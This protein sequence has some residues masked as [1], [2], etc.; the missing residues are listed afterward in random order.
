V[1]SVATVLAGLAA[2]A[3]V[4]SE[5]APS[6]DTRRADMPRL[7]ANVSRITGGVR[8]RITGSSWH[9][10]CP[11]PR[12]DLR[13][14]RLNHWDFG[15]DLERGRLIVNEDEKHEVVL[16]MRALFHARFPIRK[17]NLVDRY[18]ADDRRS[19]AADNTSAFNC[20][21]VAGTSRWSE[22]AFGRAIDINPVENPYV[23]GSHVSPPAGRPYVDRSRNAKGMIH[24]GDEVWDA[25][26][27]VGWRWGG[28]W[29]GTK[30][31]QHFSSTGN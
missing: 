8:K 2:L 17:M 26:R 6:A 9:R 21:F 25:F 31:Y 12:R 29:S 19:M 16:A 23:S 28:D 14:I 18:G 13:L 4:P 24:H 7:E 22:H 27:D 30:D 15:R 3:G 11:V 10:G 20:R 5:G 1:T